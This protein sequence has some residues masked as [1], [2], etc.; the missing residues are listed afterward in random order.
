MAR[1]VLVTGQPGVGKTT[2]CLAA[3]RAA[4][5]AGHAVGGFVTQEERAVA[6]GPRTGFS[7]AP[8]DARGAPCAQSKGV[9][10]TEGP[11]G[12][13]MVGKWAVD[14][15]SVEATAL[16]AVS[17]E[18]RQGTA[19]MLVDEIG[20]M[21]LHSARFAP[22]VVKALD[23]SRTRVLATIPT[24]RYGHKVPF[25]EAMRARDDVVLVKLLKGTRD[26]ATEALTEVLLEALRDGSDAAIN[27]AKLEEFLDDRPVA[28]S[29]GEVG[30]ASSGGEGAKSS[31]V[32]ARQTPSL[33][34]AGPLM[35]PAD[36]AP[37]VLLLGETS[38]PYAP[39]GE[40]YAERSMWKC[41]GPALGVAGDY[42]SA[43]AAALA[44][45]VVV[46]DVLAEV[47]DKS[48]PRPSKRAKKPAEATA[49]N[50]LLSLLCAHPTISCVACNGA[51]AE[52]AFQACAGAGAALAS[53]LGRSAPRVL[54]LPS[55]SP[56]NARGGAEAKIA[57]WKEA[58]SAAVGT[59]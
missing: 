25:V 57:A 23:D 37:R 59:K 27:V 50:D 55:S 7:I 6:G 21:E 51:K 43:R 52:K 3:V 44:A 39:A 46:W 49:Y 54:K 2:A 15:P 31:G 30:G 42:Q 1:H 16:P 34:P 56:A 28:V 18:A 35:P 10:A 19:L 33:R 9:L 29:G 36:V 26:T 45:G 40:E 24:P 12:K 22:A 5:G 53:K 4:V 14:V 48:A 41:V 13:H 38:S 11:R 32:S 8:L 17:D 47:H 20:K 58:L